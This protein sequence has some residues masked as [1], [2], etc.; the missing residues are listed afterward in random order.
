MVIFSSFVFLGT[1]FGDVTLASNEVLV[2][3]TYIT[4]YAMDG[5]AFAAETLIAR[6]MGRADAS[7]LRRSALMTGFWGAV[8][9]VTTALAFAIFGPWLIDLMAKSPEVQVE[10][11]IYLPWMVVTPLIGCVAWM[12][13]GIFI[14]ATQSRDMRNM[15][16]VSFIFYWIAVWLFLPL[17]GNHGL[18]MALLVSFLVRGITLSLRYPALE[19]AAQKNKKT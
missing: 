18:W 7:R 17:W 13:D 5:F 9:C 12:M 16:I 19:A 1:R 3:F 14:G 10:A 4:A 15:M 6:A 2:Q 11:R 8:V